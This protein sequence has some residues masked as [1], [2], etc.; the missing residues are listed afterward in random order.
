MSY[1]DDPSTTGFT[2]NMDSKSL[3]DS[4]IRFFTEAVYYDNVK[5]VIGF[6][7]GDFNWGEGWHNADEVNV[8]TKHAY[9]QF[10]PDFYKNIS[11]KVGLQGYRDLYHRAIFD[12]DAAGISLATNFSNFNVDTGLYVLADDDADDSSSETL[13]V[14]DIKRKTKNH[15][16]KGS[17]IHYNIKDQFSISYFAAGANM[18]YNNLMFG[19]HFIYNTGEN[20]NLDTDI[21]GYFGYAYSG[22]KVEDFKMKLKFGYVP[23]KI[24]SDSITGLV[25]IRPNAV[26]YGLEYFF[27]GPVYDANAM[28]RDYGLVGMGNMVGVL[29]VSYKFLYANFG[30]INATNEDIDNKHI[31]NEIDFGINTNI[32]NGLNLKTV[33]AIFMPSEDF[34]YNSGD[35]TATELSMQLKYKF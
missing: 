15:L 20:K 19:G 4:R 34:D 5:A 13:G 16:L 22:Y 29:N 21:N 8:E 6:E 1:Y 14:L 27:R 12:E 23:S 24:E 32:T 33:Y 18:N 35:K 10:N 17:F 25:A 2:E 28:T 3:I 9:L 31:G 30:M 26:G 11:L 7:V